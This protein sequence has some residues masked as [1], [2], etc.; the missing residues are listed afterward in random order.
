M[1]GPVGR[2]PAP[3]A[4]GAV[5]VGDDGRIVWCGP[6]ADAPDIAEPG[7]SVHR[8][9]GILMPGMV[10]AHGHTPMVLLRGAGEGCPWNAGCTR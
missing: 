5:D 3:I 2:V 9:G 7:A 4:D 6:A 8:I 10:N 1:D